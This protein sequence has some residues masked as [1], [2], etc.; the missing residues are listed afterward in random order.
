MCDRAEAA[1]VQRRKRVRDICSEADEVCARAAQ[2][3][4]E[5]EQRQREWWQST[6]RGRAWADAWKRRRVAVVDAGVHAA[7]VA[8]DA[9]DG[10]QGE[11]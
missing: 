8:D 5:A 4:A 6:D 10:V 11:A 9:S 1:Q 3:L 2:A 7:G